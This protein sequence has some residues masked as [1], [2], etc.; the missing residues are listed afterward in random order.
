MF[1]FGIMLMHLADYFTR[2][3]YT[4]KRGKDKE[5]DANQLTGTKDV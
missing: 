1:G 4:K 5:A 3:K 2:R